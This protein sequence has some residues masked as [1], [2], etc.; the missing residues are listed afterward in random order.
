[1]RRRWLFGA[2]FSCRPM[3]AASPYGR[4]P[5]EDA[6]VDIRELEALSARM[7]EIWDWMSDHGPIPPGVTLYRAAPGVWLELPDPS[8]WRQE[9]MQ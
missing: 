9:A 8:E 6:L 2:G 7:Q 4:S 5:A 1:M 3:T